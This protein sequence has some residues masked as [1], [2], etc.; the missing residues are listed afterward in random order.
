M[1]V[2]K[3]EHRRIGRKGRRVAN[4]LFPF[5]RNSNWN[6]TGIREWNLIE[7][8][9]TVSFF[10]LLKTVTGP[11]PFSFLLESTMSH[12]W[13]WGFLLNIGC[14][15]QG[16]RKSSVRAQHGHFRPFCLCRYWFQLQQ[17]IWITGLPVGCTHCPV[18]QM[19]SLFQTYNIWLLPTRP[20]PLG[21][22]QNPSTNPCT[23]KWSSFA[24]HDVICLGLDNFWTSIDWEA[25]PI[26]RIH[27]APYRGK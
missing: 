3:K 5:P 23:R 18:M 22:K 6:W 1:R 16:T 15:W 10:S 9:S 12:H 19:E 17:V 24:L 4:C 8:W 7:S 14:H 26:W 27:L 13:S 21:Y 20:R 2:E 25:R 11:K